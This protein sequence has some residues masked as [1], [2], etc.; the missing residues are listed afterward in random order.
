MSVRI[1]PTSLKKKYIVEVDGEVYLCIEEWG[2]G[3]SEEENFLLDRYV[4]QSQVIDGR[5]REVRIQDKEIVSRIVEAITERMEAEKRESIHILYMLTPPMS[6]E[7]HEGKML[8]VFTESI[9]RYLKD[10]AEWTDDE[11]LVDSEDRRWCIDDLIGKQ[12]R[13]GNEVF[14]VQE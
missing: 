2:Q 8:M 1:L 14:I 13:I 5:M 10:S 11:I 9:I 12:V 6:S 7:A 4:I 3:K